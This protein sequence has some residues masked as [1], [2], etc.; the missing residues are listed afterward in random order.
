ML[1]L[2]VCPLCPNLSKHNFMCLVTVNNNCCN[3]IILFLSVRQMMLKWSHV[4]HTVYTNQTT[5]LVLN[6]KSLKDKAHES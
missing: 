4:K 2:R 1:A 3:N 5:L 6:S